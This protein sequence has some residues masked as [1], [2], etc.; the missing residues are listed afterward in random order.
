MGRGVLGGAGPVSSLSGF[1]R[2]PAPPASPARHVALPRPG[3][4]EGGSRAPW[5]FKVDV[6]ASVGR[7]SGDGGRWESTAGISSRSLP[8]RGVRN[9]WFSHCG[10][11]RAA[12]AGQDLDA[13]G[14][15]LCGQGRGPGAG[16]GLRALPGSPSWAGS[17]ASAPE[18]PLRQLSA[19]T[20]GWLSPLRPGRL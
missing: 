17:D 16:R 18:G 8:S 14:A 15:R 2:W 19:R 1:P 11:K 13:S 7:L 12:G 4:P 3:A 10:S 20:P 9:L 6:G 5:V